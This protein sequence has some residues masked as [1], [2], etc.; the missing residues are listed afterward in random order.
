[1]PHEQ[2]TKLKIA[3]QTQGGWG[4][5]GEGVGASRGRGWVGASRGG[6]G[7]GR[8]KVPPSLAVCLLVPNECMDIILVARRRDGKDLVCWACRVSRA[9]SGH[10]KV[11]DV[12]VVVV[13]V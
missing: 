2:R 13:V 12:V 8:P 7:W 9:Q 1:M 4:L 3:R 11:G 5:P 10:N 6:G